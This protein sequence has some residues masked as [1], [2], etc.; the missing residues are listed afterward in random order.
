MALATW[1]KKK[2]HMSSQGKLVASFTQALTFHQQQMKIHA[3]QF[4]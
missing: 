1:Q 3:P 2:G 4:L